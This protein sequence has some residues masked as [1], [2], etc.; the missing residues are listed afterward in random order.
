M[1]AGEWGFQELLRRGLI[2]Y[3]DVNEVRGGTVRGV[4]LACA[5]Y[6]LYCCVVL[7][8]MDTIKCNLIQHLGINEVRV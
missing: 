1:C 6:I 4:L 5:T 7:C 3:L 2:E 8:T